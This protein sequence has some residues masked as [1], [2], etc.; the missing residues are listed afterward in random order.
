MVKKAALRDE[1]ALPQTA[2][3]TA[4]HFKQISTATARQSTAATAI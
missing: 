2:C 1:S 3:R 4:V